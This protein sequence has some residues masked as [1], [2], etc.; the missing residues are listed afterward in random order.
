MQ[1]QTIAGHANLFQPIFAHLAKLFV[2]QGVNKIR[3][4]GGE[5]TLRQGLREL[6]QEMNQLRQ[7]GLEKI[8]M[9]SNGLALHRKLAA[10][11]TNFVDA[12]RNK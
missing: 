1:R 2:S 6:I 12:L 10:S 9:T 8:C 5:P 4:T 7:D 3:L 11:Q